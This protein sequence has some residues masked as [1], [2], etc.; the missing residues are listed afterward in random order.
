MILGYF[1]QYAPGSPKYHA[2]T[3]TICVFRCCLSCKFGW[4]DLIPNTV[5]IT[6]WPDSMNYE[7]EIINFTTSSTK[8]NSMNGLCMRDMICSLLW[9][10][11]FQLHVEVITLP[12]HL[13]SNPLLRLDLFSPCFLH[14]V[15]IFCCCSFIIVMLFAIQIIHLSQLMS[16]L[17]VNRTY[18]S[19][20]KNWLLA[21]MFI[22]NTNV[23][24]KKTWRP[25]E[26]QDWGHK[27][28]SS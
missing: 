11:W 16:T 9:S 6:Y 10:T 27:R 13:I 20:F 25:R 24:M 19:F 7:D 18:F 15:L 21:E 17:K 26:K 28:P 14:L 8:W 1:N 12:E 23:T 22:T 4:W 5:W 3:L 2:V